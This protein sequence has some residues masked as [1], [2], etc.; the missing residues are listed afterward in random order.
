[1][2]WHQGE[3]DASLAEGEY[4]KLLPAFI[5]RVRKDL[6]APDLP[7]VV[8]EVF[9]NGHR[10][11]VRAGERATTQAVSN[12]LFVPASDLKTSD[13]GTHFDTP[14]QIKLGGRIAEAWLA[15]AKRS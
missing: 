3:S 14:S 1:M 2:I 13:N 10:D 12:T 11:R 9:D 8:A 7:F 6:N 15:Y 4:Q 5:A